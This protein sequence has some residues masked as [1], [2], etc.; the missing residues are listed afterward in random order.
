MAKKVFN[1]YQG[2]MAELSTKLLLNGK[3]LSQPFL[4]QLVTYKLNAK[5]IKGIPNKV[6][7]GKPI[8]IIEVRS[9][10]TMA[11]TE[12]ADAT[13]AAPQDDDASNVPTGDAVSTEADATVHTEADAAVTA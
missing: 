3:P 9:S 10:A 7:K 6:G 13:A 5:K 4:S 2:T 1:T 11:F 12:V 8:N